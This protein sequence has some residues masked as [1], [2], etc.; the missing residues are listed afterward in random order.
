MQDSITEKMRFVGI[1][2]KKVEAEFNGGQ[3]VSDAGILL[4]RQADRKLKLTEKLS[5]RIKDERH[6][7]YVQHGI[8]RILAQRIYAIAC[9]YEDI[10][11]HKELRKDPIFKLSGNIVK[12]D[13]KYLA[14]PSTI[15]RLENK[16]TR[17]DMIR[18]S[19]L[20]IDRFIASY[21][22]KP[23]ELILDFDATDDEVHGKQ[24]KRFFHGYYDS[25]CYLPLYVFCG[26]KLLVSYL[27]PSNIDAA[28]H[29]WAI[30]K[31]LTNR[32]RSEWPKVK[33]TIRADS[34]FCRHRMLS[35]CERHG[36]FYIIGIGKNNVLMREAKELIELSRSAYAITDEKVR[37]F[38]EIK[39]SAKTWEKERRVIV[40]AE[41]LSKGENIRFVV[42][43][44]TDNTAE[45][46]YDE[47]YVKRGDMENRIKEQQLDLFADRTSC[48]K[49]LSNQFRLFL[50]SFAYVLIDYIRTV[51]L[52]STKY[53][54]AQAGTIRLKFLKAG[55]IITEN[56]RRI[57]INISETFVYKDIFCLIAKRLL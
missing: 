38:G 32:L 52:S 13:E 55:A 36:I 30:L 10:N 34:G 29:A 51:G 15:S 3:I 28:K 2:S 37:I 56:T 26:S 47:I 16:V 35:W 5:R 6:A 19:E 46:L 20:L 43:N 39:Y 27:R 1:K 9:G 17:K 7:S 41:Q 11:D 45:Y 18:I 12:E 48:C 53:A 8:G 49:F 33:I 54:N 57:F 31:M 22:K 14:S 50:A 40:K 42:T 24:E 4:L 21:D 44:I 23:K 25:Y